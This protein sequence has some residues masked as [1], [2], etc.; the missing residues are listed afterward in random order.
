MIP[1][2]INIWM[3]AGKG[4]TGS[5][6]ESPLFLGGYFGFVQIKTAKSSL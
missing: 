6:L 5:T 3:T 4:G 1:K 2:K